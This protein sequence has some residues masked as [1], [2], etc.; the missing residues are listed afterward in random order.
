M[1][2]VADEAG[3]R[4]VMSVKS[5]PVVAEIEPIPKPIAQPIGSDILELKPVTQSEMIAQMEAEDEPIQP[6]QQHNKPEPQPEPETIVQQYSGNYPSDGGLETV[7][8]DDAVIINIPLA[9]P[10]IADDPYAITPE[11]K[12]RPDEIYTDDAVIIEALLA[13]ADSQEVDSQI[14]KEAG[15]T[16]E[17]SQFDGSVYVNSLVHR[18]MQEVYSYIYQQQLKEREMAYRQQIEGTGLVGEQEDNPEYQTGELPPINASSLSDEE[19]QRLVALQNEYNNNQNKGQEAALSQT[20]EN[21]SPQAEKKQIEGEDAAY[22]QQVY[23]YLQQLRDT[24]EAEGLQEG[25]IQDDSIYGL[26]GGQ[27]LDESEYWATLMQ[28]YLEEKYKQEMIAQHKHNS[29][30]DSGLWDQD[31]GYRQQQQVPAIPQDSFLHTSCRRI[32]ALV[33]QQLQQQFFNALV[34]STSSN[35]VPAWFMTQVFKLTIL[36]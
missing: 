11:S 15:E 29:K 34:P 3:Y 25:Y 10:P 13:A 19:Y 6:V 23:Q 30:F 36:I 31:A 27:P 33:Q 4:P 17:A 7:V 22:V 21:A 35:V 28:Y 8:E 14:K 26:N 20:V 1:D 2:Y 18:V 5:A 9:D 12:P 16:G 32:L 24:K